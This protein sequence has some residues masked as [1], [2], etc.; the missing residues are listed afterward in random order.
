MT[1]LCV[2][3]W[4]S[5]PNSR[6]LNLM[7]FFL[8]S[9]ICNN[10]ITASCQ[11]YYELLVLDL[12]VFIVACDEA[13][14]FILEGLGCFSLLLGTLSCHSREGERARRRLWLTLV[15]L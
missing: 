15:E 12:M 14:L 1:A 6:L 10:T 7:H 9:R 3:C 4:A 5:H 11:D 13:S 2:D 8:V